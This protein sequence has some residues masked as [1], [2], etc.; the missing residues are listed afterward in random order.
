LRGREC[1][2]AEDDGQRQ[3]FHEALSLGETLGCC[4]S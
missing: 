1:G 2:G 3:V 4:V